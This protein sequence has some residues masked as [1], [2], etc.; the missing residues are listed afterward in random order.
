MTL[1]NK[2]MITRDATV[3]ARRVRALLEFSATRGGSRARLLK[4]A[5]IDPADLEDQDKRLPFSKYVALMRA[6]Q[7]LCADPALALHFGEATDLAEISLIG[8][9]GG[10]DTL[11]GGGFAMMNRY[12]RL[13]F[14]VTAAGIERFH[15]EQNADELWLIDARPNANDFH[16]L[17]ECTFARMASTIRRFFGDKPVVRAVHVTHAAPAYRAEY[18]RIF[19]VPVT[20]GSDQN[21][22]VLSQDIWNTPPP[23]SPRISDYASGVVTAHAEALLKELKRSDSVRGRVESVLIPLLP[24]GDAGI[25][26]VASKLGLSRQTLFRRLKAEGVTFEELLD[27]LRHNIAL[28]YLTQKNISV[29]ET[30]YL[31]GFSDPA[32][33]SRAFKRW[34]GKSPGKIGRRSR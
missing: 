20:F 29:S 21:A 10:A 22:L 7:E 13:D 18:D 23:E 31:V 24:G 12:T 26:I 25:D 19:Q 34:T 16:E 2:A 17:T 28:H 32:A 27:E 8:M 30:A 33:F 4:R 5:R 11:A 9:V 15:I 6:A 3:A 14:D 1:R